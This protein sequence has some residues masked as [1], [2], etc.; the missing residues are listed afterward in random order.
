SSAHDGRLWTRRSNHPSAATPA[1]AR[2]RLQGDRSQRVVIMTGPSNGIGRVDGRYSEHCSTDQ[3]T[4]VPSAF[5]PAPLAGSIAGEATVLLRK[6]LLADALVVLGKGLV[7]GTMARVHSQGARQ[8]AYSVSLFAEAEQ[9]HA[10]FAARDGIV[11]L[12]HCSLLELEQPFTGLL[13]LSEPSRCLLRLLLAAK[14]PQA[15][16]QGVV[17]LPVVGPQPPAL[18]HQ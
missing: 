8:P 14:S 5:S 2:K 4:A 18:A 16:A 11:R 3:R 7:R 1:S 17:C 12:L 13:E 9:Q 15:Q 10:R 6:V